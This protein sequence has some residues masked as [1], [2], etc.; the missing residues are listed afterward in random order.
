MSYILTALA[1]ATL[2]F[3][4]A[5]YLSGARKNDDDLLAA[6]N[7]LDATRI[8]FMERSQSHVMY[9]NDLTS[10]GVLDKDDRFSYSAPSLRAALDGARHRA[11]P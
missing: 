8:D 11:K 9:H 2:G 7:E 4:L 1:A 5:T 6:S 3:L 10:W